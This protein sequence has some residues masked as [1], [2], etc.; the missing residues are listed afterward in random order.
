MRL[1]W[2]TERAIWTG[3]VRRCYLPIDTNFDLYGGRGIRVCQRWL[4]SYRNF[5][6]DMGPRP[7]NTHSID[8][9]DNNGD[10]SKENCRWA[11][12]REQARN[13]RDNVWIDFAGE[14][15][16]LAEWSRR[17]GLHPST[18]GRRIASCWPAGEALGLVPRSETTPELRQPTIYD[19]SP[20]QARVLAILNEFVASHGVPPTIRELCSLAGFRSTNAAT[21][22]LVALE[23]KGLVSWDRGKART[24]AVHCLDGAQGAA[25][26]L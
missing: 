22:H 14:R 1:P 9:I 19:P 5:L 23:R 17:T 25:V 10:Y 13:R 11:N 3:M 26:A 12:R 15:L 18:I 4:D 7:S 16:I 8:R 2:T 6:A 20:A 21:C 24:I